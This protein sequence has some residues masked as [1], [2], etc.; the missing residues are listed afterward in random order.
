MD[1]LTARGIIE[2]ALERDQAALSVNANDK[3]QTIQRIVLDLGT[4]R[5][6]EMPLEI[7]FGFKGILCDTATD[8]ATYIYCKPNTRED[9]QSF[10]K[11]KLNDAWKVE[12][13]VARAYLHWP[14]QTGKT[15]ELLLFN[16]SEFRSG[17]MISVNAGGVSINEGSSIS[18]I[19]SVN[20][21]AAT[22]D[23][24]A[25]SNLNRKVS[26]IQNQTSADLWIGGSSAVTSSG[27][28]QGIKIPADGIIYYRN[29][30]PLYA[31]SVAGGRVNRTDEE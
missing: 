16:N 14:A 23:L 25:P 6:P 24:I 9:H 30:A 17:S 20:L 27:A 13:P 18:A 1:N 15:I 5:D 2:R 10:F 4:K 28:T 7:N 11:I 12:F 8:T 21:S 26:T 3:P 19:V 31:Y 22:A 29:T